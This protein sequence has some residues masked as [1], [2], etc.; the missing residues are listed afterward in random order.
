MITF[1]NI[2]IKGIIA[3]I[4]TVILKTIIAELG[5][6]KNSNSKNISRMVIIARVTKSNIDN[7]SISSHNNSNIN[8]NNDTNSKK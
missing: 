3:Q 1:K 8:S 6:Y 5:N 2:R 7:K 4:V